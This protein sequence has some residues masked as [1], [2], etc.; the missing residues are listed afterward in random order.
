MRVIC[1][2]F[3]LANLAAVPAALAGQIAT[4]YWRG[5]SIDEVERIKDEPVEHVALSKHGIT[6]LGIEREGGIQS[7]PAYVF[8]VTRNGRCEY[9]GGSGSAK[10]G[11][12]TGRVSPYS[13]HSVAYFIAQ[14]GYFEFGD[15]YS[16]HLADANTV[17]TMAERNGT[18]KYIMR[19]VGGPHELRL[20][21]RLLD[22]LLAEVKWDEES[23]K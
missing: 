23:G 20:V 10:Q 15:T 6:K 19:Y 5:H 11:L 22:S 17:Y 2:V 12:H 21:E 18:K 4:A 1:L 7:A 9:Y 14:L 16:S 3:I 13:F 8:Y